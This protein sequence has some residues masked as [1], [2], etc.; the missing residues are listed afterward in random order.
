[1]LVHTDILVF[2]D[3]EVFVEV[4]VVWYTEHMVET[5]GCPSELP[6]HC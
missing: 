6:A 4:L 2:L 1:M 3:V 5:A